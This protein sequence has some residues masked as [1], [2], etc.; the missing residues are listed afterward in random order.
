[1]ILYITNLYIYFYLSGDITK[2]SFY[3]MVGIH[4][5]VK[6]VMSYQNTSAAITNE[7]TSDGLHDYFRRAVQRL[8]EQT[9]KSQK[10]LL[11]Q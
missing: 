11:K 9:E 1:M 7:Q 8:K 3:G 10:E 4:D 6:N 5:L 2:K